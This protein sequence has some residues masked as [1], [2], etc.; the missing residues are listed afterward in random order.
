M[1]F[2]GL[3][4]NFRLENRMRKTTEKKLYEGLGEGLG[5]LVPSK[6]YFDHLAKGITEEEVSSTAQRRVFLS[7]RCFQ[8]KACVAFAAIT[9]KDTRLGHGLR[10]TGIAGSSCTRHESVR[11]LGF[12][13]LLKGERYVFRVHLGVSSLNNE[14][15]HFYGLCVLG[16]PPW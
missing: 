16:K 2:I 14:Q 15:V 10:A 4:A 5:C 13:D 3:D 9:Q 1:L 6:H 11:P 12:A 7:S 8:A